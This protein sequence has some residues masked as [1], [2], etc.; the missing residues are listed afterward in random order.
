MDKTV[1]KVSTDC[2]EPEPNP[3]PVEDVK[4]T[5]CPRK[6]EESEYVADHGR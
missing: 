4:E 3:L 6:T 5:I 2:V 1:E